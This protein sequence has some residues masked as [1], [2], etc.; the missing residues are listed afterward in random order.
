MGETVY[1]RVYHILL[2]RDII[3]MFDCILF[4]KC[5][6]QAETNLTIKL[7]S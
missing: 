3:H 4:L 6:L 1:Y 7:S 2:Q 5:V